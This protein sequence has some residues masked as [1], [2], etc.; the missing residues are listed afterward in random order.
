MSPADLRPYE[1]LQKAA[2]FFER[3]DVP[4]RIVGSMA[5]MAYSEARFTNDIDFL[6]DLREEHLEPLE[7]EFPAP[8]YYVSPTA[9][10]EAIR[11]R[12][13]FNIIHG[14]SGLKL[15]I[16][17]RKETEFSRL[18]ISHGRRLKSD[19][20]YEAWF[21]SPENVILMKLRYFQEG[22]SEKHL[23]DIASILLIQE[24][25]IDGGYI[26]EWAA[27]L[28]VTAEWDLVRQRVDEAT[29]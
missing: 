4:Y 26:T 1:L 5:S 16:I 11:E 19:G 17:Q 12:R 27:K 20:F 28:G 9:A 22:G 18:D 24:N 7:Q 15:D 14:P 2:N 8:D 29:S 6:V 21:G 3:L 10:R 13:Q 23:R 25:A